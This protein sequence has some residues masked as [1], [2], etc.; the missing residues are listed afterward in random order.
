MFGLKL[1]K[2]GSGTSFGG[3][4]IVP[5]ADPRFALVGDSLT[6]YGQQGISLN[7]RTLTRDAAGLVTVA[8]TNHGV[9]GTPDVNIVNCS[10]TS[11]EYFGPKITIDANSFSYQTSVT[12]AAGNISGGALTQVVI[13]NRNQGVGY[14]AW[15]QNLMGGGG[16]L[17]G[18]FGQGGDQADAMAAS[19]TLAC[20]TAAEFVIICAGINDINS[21]GASGATVV[22]RVTT[23]VDTI[24]AAGKKCVILSV[25]PLGSAFATTG[26]NTA[27]LAANAGFAALH[28]G[29][30][31]FYVDAHQDLVDT[32]ATQ[33]TDGRAWT[34]ATSDGV[35][36][37]E[38]A[39]KLIAG[40]IHSAISAWITVVN[41]LP[42]A[43]GNMPTIPGYTAIREYGE[44]DST[45]GG[46]QGTGSTGT[47]ATKQTTLSS[48]AATTI[49]NSLVDRGSS[50]LGYYNHQVITPGGA[51]IVSNY[52]MTNSGV[53]IGSL[54]LTTSDTVIF[55]LELSVTG[56]IAA[57]MSMLSLVIQSNS[58]G[59]F[60]LASCGDFIALANSTY[61][62]DD[63]TDVIL[64]TGP[65]KLNASVTHLLSKLETR[66]TGVG[67]PHTMRQGRVVLFKKD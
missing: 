25:T 55:A 34:W 9:F 45:G 53:T 51:H 14:W 13:Q 11:Y 56:A 60:G 3:V 6:Q 35:H 52:W 4:P 44:W 59:A 65:F 36:W 16:R 39:A 50:A 40:R 57:N 29:T 32:G 31:I 8:F 28:N 54:G 18:N 47:L 12:G 2:M 61:R 24:T 41:C 33:F 10:D 42:T 27:T 21:G 43:S 58:S 5:I 23:H 62:N 19:V 66:Y 63:L 20:A 38:R 7:T 15:L 37:G 64:M 1:G 67:T 49:V 22:S 30:T 48:N 17:V 26:K 46:T